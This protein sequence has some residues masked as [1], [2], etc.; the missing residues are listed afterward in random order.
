MAG[1]QAAPR[2]RATPKTRRTVQTLDSV[3]AQQIKALRHKRGTSQQ[4]LA[5]RIRETQSTVARIESGRRAIT[6]EELLRIAAALD[7]APVELLAGSFEPADVPVL[8]QLRLSPREARRWIRGDSPIPNSDEQAYFENT[9]AEVALERREL[10]AEIMDHRNRLE[11][12]RLVAEGRV[13]EARPE[14][15]WLAEAIE[16][17]LSENKSFGWFGPVERESEGQDG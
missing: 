6:V 1:K 14:I 9:S 8:G 13:E 3:I 16:K 5:K 12:A 4:E 15:R 7:V 10:L 2:K 11:V 17:A